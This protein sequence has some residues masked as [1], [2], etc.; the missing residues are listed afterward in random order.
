[1]RRVRPRG[2]QIRQFILDN[3]EANPAAIARLV[4][5]KFGISRQAANN[6]LQRLVQEGCLSSTGNTRQRVYRLAPLVEWQKR[7]DISPSLED[8]LVWTRDVRP[9][10]GALPDNVLNI[11]QTVFTEIFNNAVEHSGGT[12]V[13]VGV[14]KS[15]ARAEMHLFDDGVG[16][17]AKIRHAFSL[18][19]EQHA[20][21]E[22][23]KG[24]LTTDPKNHS[25]EGIFFSSRMV[26]DF[27]IGSGDAFWSHHYGDAE[28]FIL[29]FDRKGKSGTIVGMVLSNHASRTAKQVYDQFTSGDD[30][31]F[32]KTVVPVKLAKL[33]SDALVSRSQAKRVVA[34]FEQFRIVM[35]DFQ[36][37]ESIGQAFA[38]EIF[39]VFSEEHPEVELQVVNA[40]ASIK[41]MIAH[42]TPDRKQ[43]SAL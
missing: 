40:S 41:S 30:Y 23:A 18:P 31:G 43:E 8:N 2:E 37:L 12:H 22:L 26:D 25:G 33:G 39:R 35:L 9:A 1:M 7:Y 5:A 36:D 34:R 13:V 20:V 19:D 21:L 24:K 16:I 17:F 28:D 32:T 11:W 38:D 10:L 6:H 14:R 15:A 4:A 42:V 3:V 29:D 27:F